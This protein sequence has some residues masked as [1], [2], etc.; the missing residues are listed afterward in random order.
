MDTLVPLSRVFSSCDTDKA[1]AVPLD[2]LLSALNRN[3]KV[4]DLIGLRQLW[5]GSA[6]A[7]AFAARNLG[8]SEDYAADAVAAFAERLLKVA[9]ESRLANLRARGANGTGDNGQRRSMNVITW[10]QFIAAFHAEMLSNLEALRGQLVLGGQHESDLSSDDA[11][12]ISRAISERISALEV[13]QRGTGTAPTVIAA[14]GD[15][16]SLDPESFSYEQ[17]QNAPPPQ[18]NLPLQQVP[19]VGALMAVP[20][21]AFSYEQQPKQPDEGE[22]ERGTIARRQQSPAAPSASAASTSVQL[23]TLPTQRLSTLGAGAVSPPDSICQLEDSSVSLSL[24]PVVTQASEIV[25]S[26]SEDRDCVWHGQ[27]FEPDEVKTLLE[28]DN[29]IDTRTSNRQAQQTGTGLALSPPLDEYRQSSGKTCILRA[30]P[31]LLPSTSPPQ[32]SIIKNSMTLDT[33]A[34]LPLQNSADTKPVSASAKREDLSLRVPPPLPPPRKDPPPPTAPPPASEV[35]SSGDTR[36]AI[37]APAPCQALTVQVQFSPS[38]KKSEECGVTKASLVPLPSP[39][40]TP[41]N[42]KHRGRRISV[43]EMSPTGAMLVTYHH[44]FE[45][46]Q[47]TKDA[48]GDIL[49]DENQQQS[50][51]EQDSAQQ[52]YEEPMII[53]YIL[54]RMKLDRSDPYVSYAEELLRNLERITL[55]CDKVSAVLGDYSFLGDLT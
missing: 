49:E 37:P 10:E 47:E 27:T 54:D 13:A 2:T 50:G 1:D 35:L 43:T 32:P 38:N 28:L 52:Q 46:N 40:F 39:K 18:N 19:V 31:Q 53:D 9:A 25:S 4:H 15:G 34:L 41:T 23:T 42:G 51:H 36:I 11:A 7:R 17:H 48:E 22:D 24:V 26:L 29:I 30:L 44:H 14:A 3:A 21:D 20:P 33:S 12:A 6:S 16:P 55:A 45:D 5:T 8:G